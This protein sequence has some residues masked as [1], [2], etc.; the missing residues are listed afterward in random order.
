MNAPRRFQ[1]PAIAIF[2]LT[3]LFNSHRAQALRGEE[4]KNAPPESS[5]DELFRAK[6]H[7]I[8][9]KKCAGCH[10]DDPKMI[11]GKLD[12]RSRAGLLRP[13]ESGQTALTPGA[14]NKSRLYQA[15]AWND[16]ALRMPPQERNRLTP[17]EVEAVRQ[18]IDGGAP[19]PEASPI[20]RPGAKAEAADG[21]AVST[22]GG[23]APEWTNRKYR[24]ED[25]WSFQPVQR[26]AVPRGGH[27]I[28]AFLAQ[29]L[30]A[31]G[32]TPAPPADRRTLIWRATFDL[33]GL[34]PTP[35]QV[36]SFLKDD[37]ADPFAKLMARLLQSPAF[38]EQM[39][40][41]W[42]DVIRFADTGGFANDF[43]RPNA[44]RFRDY[45]IRSFNNDKPFDRFI[46]EQVAG[47][48]LGPDD[49]ELAI[50]AGFL[51]TGPW[52]QTGMTVAAI[53]RQQFLDDVTHHVGVAFLGVG[54]RCAS[55]H[56]HKFDPLPT[57]DYYRLQAVFATTQ[58]A[59]R[60][61]PFLPV[62][63]TA[64][65]DKAKAD[66]QR[67]LHATEAVLDGL[68]QKT[69]EAQAAFLKERKVSSFSELPADQERIN[70]GLTRDEISLRKV[71]E[72]RKAYLER[73]ALRHEPYA[74]SVYSGAANNYTSVKAINLAPAKRDG[75]APTTQILIG[76]SLEAPAD[77]V[78]PGVL[79]AVPGSNDALAPTAWNS[80]PQ[81]L[82]G[83]RLA[84]ANW[85]ASPNNSLTARVIVNR[86]W[87]WHFGKGLVATPNNFGKMGARPTHP[88]LLDWLATW[89]VEHGWSL[90]KLH[91]LIMTSAAY[92][93]SGLHPDMKRLQDVDA[94]NELLAVFS[95]R[96][97]AAEEIRDAMLAV[98][99]E[100]NP[101]MGGPGV[102]PE[103]NW[104]VAFQPRHI[105]GSIAP[106]YQ[107]SPRPDQRN[108][109]TIYAF[110]YR[111]FSDPFLEVFNR[112]GCETSCERRDA[113]TVT[114]QVFALFNSQ[115]AQN[116]ALALAAA[117]EAKERTS[118]GQI[119]LAF[120]M[121]YG[122][123]PSADELRKGGAHIEKMRLGHE[124]QAPAPVPLPTK[125]VRRKVE[126]MTGEE[127]TW[128]EELDRMHGYRRDLMPW[129]LGPRT[130]ALADLCLVLLNSNEFLYVR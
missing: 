17:E 104:E 97:L 12:V 19:W 8:L 55:C 112:P 11:Q 4:K 26:R 105:M 43:E 13:A 5:A 2:A 84:L 91:A 122:R 96:R 67:R 62:E 33:T 114:P 59:E 27:P 56:D 53:T 39:A 38:G 71:L 92:Q 89:F 115:F 31:K 20:A 42:F 63:N 83:R 40:R 85:I 7:G 90:K 32:L 95:P 58:F 25:I 110:R 61:V 22:S 109:R 103:I 126:E 1:A 10:G 29:R 81:A 34:P 127:T 80:V 76:G 130:R 125:I 30:E 113:T 6:V 47:D 116:R 16:A 23:L 3:A 123:P 36:D 82:S 45:V 74:F 120:R 48:E 79:S 66:V 108:R 15:I 73:E 24:P 18:W 14:A 119:L 100:L 57:R 121:V 129:D 37:S 52:E 35:E 102:F 111:T 46:V 101:A 93:R 69:K 124:R 28:D 117:L 50:A 68:K 77:R 78:T 75:A 87:Q 21:V 106:A 118:A 44:W 60:S 49:P 65:F 128:V 94:K 99:G 107:P 41:H 72:K 98:T 88:E 9:Q 54:L 70:L 64:G 51:R 86:V